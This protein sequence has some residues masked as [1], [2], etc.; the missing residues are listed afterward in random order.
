MTNSVTAH[1]VHF[2]V[3]CLLLLSYI[4]YKEVHDPQIHES[5]LL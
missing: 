4:P 5:L 2:M 1:H 3:S